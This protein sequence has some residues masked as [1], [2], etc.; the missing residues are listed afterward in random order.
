[1]LN[2]LAQ[3]DKAIDIKAFGPDHTK[4][5]VASYRNNLRLAPKPKGSS[6]KL[7]LKSFEKANLPHKAKTVQKIIFS[8]KN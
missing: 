2:I 4:K 1:M 3:Y 8:L 7:S 5:V 6:T